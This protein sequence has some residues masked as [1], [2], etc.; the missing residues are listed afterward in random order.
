MELSM[1][2]YLDKLGRD[3]HRELAPPRY[4]PIDPK[5]LKLK[6]R[7]KDDIAPKQL[8]ER[9]QSLIGKLLYPASQLRVDV[10]FAVGYLAR[11]M[12]NPTELHFQYAMQVVDYL[13]STKALTMGYQ[14][15]ASTPDLAIDVYCKASSPSPPGN[16]GLHAYSDASFADAEDRKS[17]SGYLFKLAGGTVCHRSSKQKLVT[18]STT[19]AEYVGLTYAA[20]EATWLKRLLR[21][22][23]YSGN[24]IHPIKLYG[25]NQ[26]SLQLVASEGHHERTKHV[27]IL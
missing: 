19:E 21:Q 20:K 26:P 12:S 13:Y 11:A 4:N 27:D 22:V 24:D 14:A 2:S 5:V 23:G 10:S 17:T 1:E 9:Y 15:P 18:T 8:T 7:A 25:D 3:Y 16:L 6:L